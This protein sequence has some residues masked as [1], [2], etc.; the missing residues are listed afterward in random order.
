MKSVIVTSIVA[1]S[2]AASWL[3]GAEPARPNLS[4]EE[5]QKRFMKSYN[6]LS[7]KEP[8][9][10]EL[11]KVVLEKLGVMISENTEMAKT[12]LNDLLGQGT[13]VSGAFNHALGNL[14][15][16]SADF[17][18]AEIQY[19]AA[20]DKHEDFQR[21]WN[22][23][24]LARF[25]LNDIEGA[26]EALSRSS[27][28]GANDAM[29]YGVIGYCHLQLGHRKSAE[30][31]YG[32]AI[33]NDPNSVEW[34]EGMAQIYM[35]TNRYSEAK[36][37]FEEL[38]SQNPER[39]EYWVLLG[40][41]YLSMEEPKKTAR[42]IEIARRIDGVDTDALELLG[43]IYLNEGAYDSAANVYAELIDRGGKSDAFNSL[44]AAKYLHLNNEADLA[45][46]LYELYPD[47]EESWS[48]ITKSLHQELA[49]DF[50]IEQSDL[51]KAIDSYNAALLNTPFNGPILIKLGEMYAE[52]GDIENAFSMYSRARRDVDNAYSAYVL[53]AQLLVENK[54][55]Q[56]AVPLIKSALNIASNDSLEEFYEQIQKAAALGAN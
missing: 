50:A 20:I 1:L 13:P 22:G 30:T 35:E 3:N 51:S 21:A 41:A 8:E 38:V 24:G 32:L 25:K 19:L 46:K 48:R 52:N 56:E 40:N 45:R 23:L 43:D 33:L 2:I 4:G 53:H 10:T 16:E 54:R 26:L 18:N 27:L 42:C 47:V 9:V 31:A 14:Y 34:S 49:G 55:Y 37:V 11:E 5:F 28:M 12:M 15:Y 39:S 6:A 44:R 17:L 29:T 36:G 7:T